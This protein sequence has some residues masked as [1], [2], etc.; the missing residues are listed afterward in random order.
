MK[1]QMTRVPVK[2]PSSIAG[3][4]ERDSRPDFIWVIHDAKGSAV[5]LR[6]QIYIAHKIGLIDETVQS[7]MVPEL[8]E[9]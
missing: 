5:E 8:R 3:G 6:I 1:G 7:E 9:I 4:A 2:I